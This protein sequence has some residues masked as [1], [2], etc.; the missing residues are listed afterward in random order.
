MSWHPISTR[1]RIRRTLRST[2]SSE[3]EALIDRQFDYSRLILRDFAPSDKLAERHCTVVSLP[4]L[5]GA[6]LERTTFRHPSKDQTD[7]PMRVLRIELRASLRANGPSVRFEDEDVRRQFYHEMDGLIP[8]L[9][10]TSRKRIASYFPADYSVFVRITFEPATNTANILIWFDDPTIRWPAGLLAR[11]A[12]KLSVPVLSHALSETFEQRIQG[13]AMHFERT[14]ARIISLAP[15]RI[16]SD[17]IV[18]TIGVFGAT[19]LFWLYGLPLVLT[20]IAGTAGP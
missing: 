16:W 3:T 18:L 13:V 17:P 7:F 2:L 14:N 19:T 15:M 4:H 12:W 8:E 20:K 10:E 9:T 11:R 5:E 6:E 1:S